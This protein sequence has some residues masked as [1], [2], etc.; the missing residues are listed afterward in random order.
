[1]AV[2]SSLSNALPPLLLLHQFV[3]EYELTAK[4][5]VG[6]VDKLSYSLW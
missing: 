2:T 5:T 1:M 3:A 6:H 4:G